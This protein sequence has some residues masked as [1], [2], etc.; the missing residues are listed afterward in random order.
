MPDY[1]L[2]PPAIKQLQ[3]KVLRRMGPLMLFAMVMP[4]GIFYLRGM[5]LRALFITLPI[6]GVAAAVALRRSRKQLQESLSSICI[7]LEGD[8]LTRRQAGLNEI[9]LHRQEI[10][11]IRETRSVGLTLYSSDRRKRV[12]IPRLL[13]GYEELRERLSSWGTVTEGRF[14]PMLATYGATLVVLCLFGLFL[15][16][17]TPGVVIVSGSIMCVF[18]MGSSI[19][20]WRSPSVDRNV[21]KRLW[22]VAFVLVMIAVRMYAALR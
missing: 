6:L 1:R 11:Q 22:V 9:S 13:D 12:G 18:M 16:S 14:P 15:R 2:S 20:L 8:V 17:S 5:S 3:G 4:L 7:T 19:Y 21:K 10:T